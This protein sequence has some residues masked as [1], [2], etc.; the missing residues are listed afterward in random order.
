MLLRFSKYGRVHILPCPIPIPKIRLPKVIRGLAWFLACVFLFGGLIAGGAI[1]I[2]VIEQDPPFLE[3]IAYGAT[4]V[5]LWLA[6]WWLIDIFEF[7]TPEEQ[8]AAEQTALQAEQSAKER[9]DRKARR[10]AKIDGHLRRWY[11]RYPFAIILIFGSI[12]IY[13][14]TANN[15]WKAIVVSAGALVLAAVAAYELSLLFLV[16]GAFYLIIQ[17]II[18]IPQNIAIILAAL[19]IAAAVVGRRLH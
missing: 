9:A 12:F 10:D 6:A 14:H 18:A 5:A 19:I 16:F 2:A 1:L 11:C 3:V 13:P 8:V 17:G 7:R 15:E 4:M